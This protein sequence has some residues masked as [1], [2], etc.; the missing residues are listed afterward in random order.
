MRLSNRTTKRTMLTGSM[1]SCKTA[2]ITMTLR[3]PSEI[4][5]AINPI[6]SIYLKT[7]TRKKVFKKNL[8]STKTGSRWMRLRK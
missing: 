6:N 3:L 2:W 7:L 5:K 4:C 1:M 8:R